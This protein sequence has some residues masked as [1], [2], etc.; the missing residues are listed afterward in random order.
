MKRGAHIVLVFLVTM[1]PLVSF[2]GTTYSGKNGQVGP[3]GGSYVPV[4]DQTTNQNLTDYMSSFNSY[5]KMFE[6]YYEEFRDQIGEKSPDGTTDVL[7]DLLSGSNPGGLAKAACARGNNLE[8]NN[9][10]AYAYKT[11]PWKDASTETGIPTDIPSAGNYVQINYSHSLRCLLQ[12]VV[13]WQ[14]L[15]LSVQIHS[16]LKTYIADAQTKQLNNQLKNKIAAANLDWSRG[17]N[18]VNDGGVMSTQPVFSTNVSQ[19]QYNTANRQL[20]HITDQAAADPAA[21]NPIGSLGIAA[22][23]RLDVAADMTRNMRGQVEDPFFFQQTATQER[24][25]SALDPNDFTKFM[26]NFNDPANKESGM[27]TFDAMLSN[28]ANSPLGAMDL[29]NDVAQTRIANQDAIT[30]QKQSNTGFIPAT[31]YDSTNAADPY[32]LD[33]QFGID[34]NPAGQNS[35]MVTDMS[36]Q[37]DRQ[38]EQGDTLDAKGGPAA[39]AQSTQLN[40]GGGVLNYDTTPLATSST[41]VNKLVKEMYDAMGIGYFGVKQ[42]TTDWARAT[43]LMIYDEMKF[44]KTEPETVVTNNRDDAPTGY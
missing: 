38:V 1:F 42:D 26:L 35:Q 39:E 25:S 15:G 43:M 36:S 28:K 7:R 6:S 11:G 3:L 44:N 27:A 12:E 4:Y 17:G 21:G 10:A 32:N 31:Q 30:L 18:A 5:G 41:V 37:G 2:A 24:L 34:A 22:P 8:G 9:N 20:E 29:A 14:K 40:T 33:Q 19:S 16:L 13:E 23:W